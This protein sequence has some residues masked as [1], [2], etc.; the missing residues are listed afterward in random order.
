MDSKEKDFEKMYSSN[1]KK[2]ILSKT[3]NIEA[4]I[5]SCFWENP[6]LYFD[7]DMLNTEKF[8]TPIWKFYFTVGQKMAIKQINTI[9]ESDVDLFLE[10]KDNLLKAYN[11][12]GG[13][14]II[15]DLQEVCDVENVSVYVREL[16]KW[17]M[18]WTI[19][20]KFTLNAEKIEQLKELDAD[21]IYNYYNVL[22][23]N[24]FTSVD[25]RVIVNN[26]ADGLEDIIAEADKGL[27]RGMNYESPI[28]SN[29][30]GGWKNG[31]LYI[32]GGLS[33]AGKTTWVQDV[34][35]PALWKSDEPCVIMLNEQDHVKWKQQFLTWIINNIVIT[36]DKHFFNAKRWVDGGFTEKEKDM[37]N[38]AVSLLR[39]KEVSG[40]I[41]I[42]ELKS[43][44][45]KDAE[46]IIKQYSAMGV[47]KFI[48]DTFKIS[49]DRN[50]SE[51]FWLS[52]QEDCRKFDDLIKPSNLNVALLLTL[53]LQ[54]GSR[55]NRYLS[56]DNI[57]MSK[58]V[59]DVGSV[60]LLMRRLFNDEYTGCTKELKVKKR[61]EGTDT[62]E[63]V[64]LDKN[65]KYIIIFIEK[66]RNGS[67]QEYQV[68]AE[69]N[70]GRLIY[71]EVGIADIPVD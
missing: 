12:F 67:S 41:I 26:L 52:M 57:G 48:L 32:L 28:L 55:M 47:K 16:L 59:L 11:D 56:M 22:L 17:D 54:K 64:V 25:D 68:V 10:G 21:G 1:M 50:E 37:L 31:Q 49:S 61:I 27:A 42:A 23:N 14:D 29:E 60:A 7:Y 53:Q 19:I 35:L 3:K 62:F 24:T 40:H 8:K 66:N 18:L 5:V 46:R 63:E 34:I 4:N 71:K 30:T 33:G 65:K 69:Q 51:A 15:N 45:Q 70:L 38:Q 20:E 2:Q 43:Y 44:S 6:K 13:F 39:D 36:N 58:N 9:N